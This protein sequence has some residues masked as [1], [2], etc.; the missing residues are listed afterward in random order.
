MNFY[1]FATENYLMYID[2]LIE[3][4]LKNLSCL[5]SNL[6][7]FCMGFQPGTFNNQLEKYK[8]FPQIEF[9]FRQVPIQVI[10]DL[11]NKNRS[12]YIL[13]LKAQLMYDICM[14]NPNEQF[15]WIDADSIIIG[16]ITPLSNILINY[17][18]A[19]T[20]RQK[21]KK[22]GKFLASLIGFAPTDK[23]MKY[24]KKVSERVSEEFSND[25]NCKNWFY[26]QIAMYDAYMDIHPKLYKLKDSQHSIHENIN[27]IVLDRRSNM[28]FEKMTE[29]VKKNENSKETY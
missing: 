20:F 1:T 18:M 26:D 9:I 15:Y 10:N 5:N 19:C 14:N 24:L 11:K 16:D 25:I 13:Q 6:T 8:H 2:L 17:D 12:G 4:F 27:S 29:L 21:Q 28:T 23:S 7:I 3:S 22:H